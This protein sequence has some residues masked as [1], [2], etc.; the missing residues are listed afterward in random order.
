MSL[1]FF[2]E[3][4]IHFSFF[5]L[6]LFFQ[7]VFSLRLEK[8]LSPSLFFFYYDFLSFLPVSPTLQALFYHLQPISELLFSQHLIFSMFAFSP[9]FFPS[10]QQPCIKRK[11]KTKKFPL[12]L[13]ISNPIYFVFIP[14]FF[15]IFFS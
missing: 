14:N 7:L 1:F 2:V 9:P 4:S 8:N 11:F 6:L 12:F 5:K 13:E 10:P 3:F 15:G